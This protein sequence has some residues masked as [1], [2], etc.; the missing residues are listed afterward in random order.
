MEPELD[1]DQGQIESDADSWICDWNKIQTQQP[2][3]AVSV[4]L[5]ER[6][7]YKTCTDEL[8]HS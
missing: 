6:S 2:A 3:Y 1:A 4:L 5:A 8:T 7:R